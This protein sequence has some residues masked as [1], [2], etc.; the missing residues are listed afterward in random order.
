VHLK[1][2]AKK[3]AIK[4]D[5]TALEL[6]ADRSDG[7]FRDSISLLDQ[8]SGLVDPKDT[9]TVD[10]IE[11]ALGMAPT[12][13][14]DKLL[15]AVEAKDIE[16]LVKTLDDTFNDGIDSAILV[17]QLTRRISDQISEKPQLIT[18]LDALIDVPKSPQPQLKLLAVL[19]AAINQKHP[20]K[21][22]AL[23]APSRE[24]SASVEELE[25]QATKPKPKI[26]KKP[27]SQK[28]ESQNFDWKKL[29]EYTRQNYIALYS[30]LI[31][32]SYELGTDD[33][34]IYTANG[35]YKKKLDDSKYSSLLSKCLQDIGVYGLDIH[36]IPTTPPLKDS[37][38]AAIAAIMG[39]GEEVSLEPAL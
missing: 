38:A 12:K 13:I 18:L 29:I 28:I 16:L 27:A 1:D 30:V 37:Q 32:C 3:E 6:I 20:K 5:D 4:I 31:K 7:S 8:L 39:G 22:I 14:I 36:T 9:I 25:K 21:T 11:D 26:S 33:L 15:E 17:S 2:I 10:L 35:F 23:S 19:G 24:I 34:T